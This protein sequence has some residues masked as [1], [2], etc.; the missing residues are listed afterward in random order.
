MEQKDWKQD[1]RLAE[2][3]PEKLQYLTDFADRISH[4]PKEQLMPAFMAM[5]METSQKNISFSDSETDLLVSVISSRMSPAE[6]KKLETLRLLAKK[7]AARS[8]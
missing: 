7:L 2:M 3:S 4:L 6:K 1:P 5:Q 8:S